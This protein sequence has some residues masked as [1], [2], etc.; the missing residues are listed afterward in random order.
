MAPIPSHVQDALDYVTKPRAKFYADEDWLDGWY[1]YARAA[2][3]G[4]RVIAKCWSGKTARRIAWALNVVAAGD[5]DA[6][7]AAQTAAGTPESQ[8]SN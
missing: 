2:R 5:S 8:A 4:D 6:W 7:L 3:G 1:V